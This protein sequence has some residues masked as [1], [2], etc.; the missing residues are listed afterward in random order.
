MSCTCADRERHDWFPMEAGAFLASATVRD[1]APWE[2]QAF[3]YMLVTSWNDIGLPADHKPLGRMLGFPEGQVAELMDGPV[4]DKWEECSQCGVLSNPNL[5]AVREKST[6]RRDEHKE[7]R[8]KAGKAGGKASGEARR[9]KAADKRDQPSI[10]RTRTKSNEP[11]RTRTESNERERN[12]ATG[13]DTTLQDTTTNPVPE[14]AVAPSP[15][16]PVVPQAQRGKLVPAQLQMLAQEFSLPADATQAFGD[17]RVYRIELGKQLT[18]SGARKLAK[19]ASDDPDQF[20]V[21]V[22]HSIEVGNQGLYPPSKGKGPNGSQ[23]LTGRAAVQQANQTAGERFIAQAKAQ[24]LSLPPGMPPERH[25][26]EL[27][28][29]EPRSARNAGEAI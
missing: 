18:Q 11:E 14:G 27:L 20:V 5:E 26:L 28:G 21:D 9:R 23:F 15:S 29:I 17:W 10:E 2:R 1:C 4:G 7:L 16:A 24:D 3:L 19:R 13:Q 6:E 12:E 25:A 8:S 22:D